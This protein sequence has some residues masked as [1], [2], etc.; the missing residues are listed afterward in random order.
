MMKVRPKK[1]MSK[2]D[3]L[4]PV[5]NMLETF[6]I[7]HGVDRVKADNIVLGRNYLSSNLKPQSNVYLKCFLDIAER[8][9]TASGSPSHAY[10]ASVSPPEDVEASSTQ[11]MSFST[12]VMRKES[13]LECS[14][15]SW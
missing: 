2:F 4:R 13:R 8:L 12:Q 5:L 10:T 15:F 6:L 14:S 7:S 9:V 3:S 1:R 11:G